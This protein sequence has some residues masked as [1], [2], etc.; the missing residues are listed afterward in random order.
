MRG[1]SAKL[2]AALLLS[3]TLPLAA[4]AV[5]LAPSQRYGALHPLLVF[6]AGI[7]G[8]LA[9]GL[10]TF[11]LWTS[12]DAPRTPARLAGLC[13]I[14]VAADGLLYAA[15]VAS[16]QELTSALLPA[17]QKLAAAALVAWMVGTSWAFHRALPAADH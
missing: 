16:G 4:A 8:L 17:L 5:P 2:L 1:I 11:G 10:A 15:H 14:L 6:V 12:K 9:G 7:P 3:V 13:A